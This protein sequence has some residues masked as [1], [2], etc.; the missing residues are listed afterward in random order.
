M[1]NRTDRRIFTEN[2]AERNHHVEVFDG[3]L[4]SDDADLCRI[5][6]LRVQSSQVNPKVRMSATPILVTTS[7]MVGRL[8]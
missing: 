8:V 4:L 3:Q 2:S 5:P 1:E 7:R 6:E